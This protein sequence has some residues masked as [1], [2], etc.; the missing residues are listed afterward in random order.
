MERFDLTGLKIG[1]LTVVRAIAMINGKL[2]WHCMCDCG[3]PKDIT[4]ERLKNGQTKSCGCLK[5][6]AMG[7][8]FRTHGKSKSSEYRIWAKIKERC[9]NTKNDNY[10]YYG[11]RGI[12]VCDRWLNSF[13]NFIAD[14]G[15]R[16]SMEHSID[17]F[18]DKDGNYEPTNCRWATQKQQTRN[19]R[20]NSLLEYN[21]IILTKAEWAERLNLSQSSFHYKLSRGK[22]LLDIIKASPLPLV[23]D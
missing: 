14:M 18:P 20:N 19:Q 15:Q 23:F 17:R 3:N 22:S 5:R 9:Y 4:G 8:N 13:E 21:G 10:H 6:D 2:F 11:G 1:R 12:R 7:D 16:P